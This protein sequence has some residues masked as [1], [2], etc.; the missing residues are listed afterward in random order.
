VDFPDLPI[1]I[2]M[3]T[4]NPFWRYPS[5]CAAGEGVGHLRVWICPAAAHLAIVTEMGL[6]ASITNSIED[7]WA[8]LATGCG[9][10]L[11]LLEHWPTDPYAD[12][13]LD[14]VIIDGGT[15]HWRRIWPT[16]PSNPGHTRFE[17]WMT[18]YGHD[19]LAAT[20]PAQ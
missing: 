4:D 18:A 14:Q 7:I 11:V 20:R 16:P 1:P 13:H 6:G 3:H 10:R 19:L 17:E 15:P 2:T 12:E 8:A 9:G 5:A